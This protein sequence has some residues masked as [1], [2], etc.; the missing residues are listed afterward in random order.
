MS[1]Y[2][3]HQSV[4]SKQSDSSQDEDHWFKKF[5]ETLQKGAVQS[6]NNDSSLFDQISSVMNGINGC[7]NWISCSKK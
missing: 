3:R 7:S 4:V 1:K 2:F 6:R 5:E